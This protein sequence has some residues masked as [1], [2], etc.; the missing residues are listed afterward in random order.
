MFLHQP[1]I[2]ECNQ[3]S[4]SHEQNQGEKRKWQRAL[5]QLT[6]CFIR[7]RPPFFSISKKDERRTLKAFPQGTDVCTVLGRSLVKH[8]STLVKLS[9]FSHLRCL[10][11]AWL[12]LPSA[13]KTELERRQ[14]SLYPTSPQTFQAHATFRGRAGRD[15]LWEVI[16]PPSH[17]LTE[18]YRDTLAPPHGWM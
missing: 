13:V 17:V 2:P 4:L 1:I 18:F 12:I 11:V 8:Y 10:I 15:C 6:R 16:T 7:T 9:N 5:L 3:L 14:R